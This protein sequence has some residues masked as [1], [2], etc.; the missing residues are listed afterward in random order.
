MAG[1]AKQWEPLLYVCGTCLAQEEIGRIEG[2]I[3]IASELLARGANPN[4]EYDFQWHRDVPRTALWS[5]LNNVKSLALA[6]VLLQNG[7]NPTDGV[8][9]HLAA[10]TGDLPALE[11][12]LRHGSRVDGI[13][14]GV[15]PLR[16]MLNWGV[17]HSVREGVQWLLEHGADPNLVS[18]ELADT[19]LHAAAQNWDQPM[20]AL[21]VKHGADI[22]RRRADG[23]T[24]HTLAALHGN[25]ASADWLL[26]Q[27]AVDEL[28][29]LERFVAACARGDG[30]SADALLKEHPE[31]RTQ[32]RAE[33]HAMTHVPAERGN[34]AVLE[35][36]L[37]R[38]F[39]PNA[40]D[41]EGVTALHRAAMHGHAEAV[42][43][44]LARG[45]DVDALDAT[46]AAAPLVWAAQGAPYGDGRHVTVARM[47]L[48]QGAAREWIPPEKAPHPESTQEQL[49]DLCRAADA[50]EA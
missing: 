7:A 30:G 3:A 9:L 27:G 49:A 45:A 24:A 37:A 19:P 31:L 1:G 50:Q 35:T 14:G 29:P 33:H 46:F 22:H 40:R 26:A 42:R 11:L 41:E 32:L 34:A 28:A 48:A 6:E 21:L 47:L 8:S 2:L 13:P 43:V 17:R 36:M 15:P 23:R 18:G 20:V 16:F 44:L 12:L 5:A 39:D 4:A 10:G 38:G 25:H